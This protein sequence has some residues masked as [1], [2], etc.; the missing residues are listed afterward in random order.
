MNFHL[1][2]LKATIYFILV[3]F[4]LL[5]LLL[6]P[7]SFLLLLFI[8]CLLDEIQLASRNHHL[9]MKCYKKTLVKHDV[10]ITSV[11]RKKNHVSTFM[12]T[13]YLYLPVLCSHVEAE[14]IIVLVCLSIWSFW[15]H[16]SHSFHIQ[17]FIFYQI[18]NIC[19]TTMPWLILG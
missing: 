3:V 13:C 11:L 2:I 5:L 19:T 8:M 10:S 18:D 12:S 7:W 16:F 4:I 17:E 1:T 14:N 15:T 6:L 9:S